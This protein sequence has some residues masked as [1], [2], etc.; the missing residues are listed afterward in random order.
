MKLYN[1]PSSLYYNPS[2]S[3]NIEQ[4]HSNASNELSYVSCYNIGFSSLNSGPSIHTCKS[5]FYHLFLPVLSFSWIVGTL[6]QYNVMPMPD[7]GTLAAMVPFFPMGSP[8]FILMLYFCFVIPA[9]S[10]GTLCT[11]G[12]PP[13]VMNN[14]LNFPKKYI[15]TLSYL[16]V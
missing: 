4:Q 10:S 3:L 5:Y 2:S 11:N 9:S 8:S 7:H 12:S 1:T 16:P 6:L 15:Y 13:A 14:P